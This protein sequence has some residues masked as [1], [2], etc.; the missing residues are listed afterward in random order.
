MTSSTPDA[1]SQRR[2]SAPVQ[3][4]PS[5]PAAPADPA[6]RLVA[7]AGVVEQRAAGEHPAGAQ[8]PGHLGDGAPRVGEAV[9][10]GEGDDQVELAVG[11]RQGADVGEPGLDLVGDPARARRRA[12]VRSSIAWA[13]SAAT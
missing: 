4:G 6:Q 9:Q 3:P 10:P 11:E 5:R 8:H 2:S 12:M 1:G 7:P 13:M